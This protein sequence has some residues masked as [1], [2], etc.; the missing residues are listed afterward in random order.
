MAS[1]FVLFHFEDSFLLL[2]THWHSKAQMVYVLKLIFFHQIGLNFIMEARFQQNG[3]VGRETWR[4]LERPKPNCLQMSKTNIPTLYL[5]T[6]QQVSIWITHNP[7]QIVP[8][9]IHSRLI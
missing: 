9:K 3:M 6:C 7:K 1:A 5:E 4:A 8:S 2:G